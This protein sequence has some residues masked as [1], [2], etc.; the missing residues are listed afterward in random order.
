MFIELTHG[1]LGER[2]EKGAFIRLESICMLQ[3][4]YSSSTRT[5]DL[6]YCLKGGRAYY[7]EFETEKQRDEQY[8]KVKSLL[9]R[10][11]GL[12]VLTFEKE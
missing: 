4:G 10:N 8:D 2:D 5:H 6:G 1:T 11:H 7:Q 3:K 9:F 12:K